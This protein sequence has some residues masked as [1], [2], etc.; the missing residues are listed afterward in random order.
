M[1]SEINAQ[2][3][4]RF[5]AREPCKGAVRGPDSAECQV[6]HRKMHS[7]PSD[8]SI[9]NSSAHIGAAYIRTRAR[10]D[11]MYLTR[12]GNETGLRA[13]ASARSL[14]QSG[15]ILRIGNIPRHPA[16][17][18]RQ[19]PDYPPRFLPSSLSGRQCIFCAGL[20]PSPKNPI[21]GSE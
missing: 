6:T 5:R 10:T 16:T 15:D 8:A 21:A 7:P 11:N 19:N 1:I 4:I 17:P 9:R 2:R 3:I 12:Y 20:N 14:A 13:R 18:L